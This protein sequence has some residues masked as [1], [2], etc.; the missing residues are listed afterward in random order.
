MRKFCFLYF[1]L[2]VNPKEISISAGHMWKITI[3]YFIKMI[4]DVDLTVTMKISILKMKIT[5]YLGIFWKVKIKIWNS[6]MLNTKMYLEILMRKSKQLKYSKKLGNLHFCYES[7]KTRQVLNQHKLAHTAPDAEDPS[8]FMSQ[9]Y[10]SNQLLSWSDVI[11][12]YFT[13]T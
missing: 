4:Q 12:M 1:F 9:L 3:K 10:I 6:R 8:V 5:F 11:V 2:G 7:L 13:I